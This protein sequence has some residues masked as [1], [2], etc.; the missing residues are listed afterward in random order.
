MGKV[1][2]LGEKAVDSVVNIV[3]SRND[4]NIMDFKQ[5]PLITAIS[6]SVNA[7]ITIKQPNLA[8][9]VDPD[10][11]GPKLGLVQVDLLDSSF[12]LYPTS[13]SNGHDAVTPTSV[14]SNKTQMEYQKGR[15]IFKGL[16]SIPAGMCRY[17]VSMNCNGRVA[18]SPLVEMANE[19][20]NR[21][22][23]NHQFYV[24]L[25]DLWVDLGLVVNAEIDFN[26][27]SQQ[28]SRYN[29]PRRANVAKRIPG[30][31]CAQVSSSEAAEWDPTDIQQ[32]T[33]I[34]GKTKY[35]QRLG[36]ALI[37]IPLLLDST[38]LRSTS[39]LKGSTTSP[40]VST[41][42]TN[43]A[44]HS[45]IIDGRQ[46]SGRGS[47]LSAVSMETGAP[48]DRRDQGVSPRSDR[49]CSVKMYPYSN[50]DCTTTTSSRFG[51]HSGR[52]AQVF[53]RTRRMVNVDGQ[54]VGGSVHTGR[55]DTPR[56]VNYS[57][58]TYAM[59]RSIGSPRSEHRSPRRQASSRTSSPRT[60]APS[61]RSRVVEPSEPQSGGLQS[62]KTCDEASDGDIRSLS[63]QGTPRADKTQSQQRI[64][65]DIPS[66]RGDC[67]PE[68]S[69][70]VGDGDFSVSRRLQYVDDTP[71]GSSLSAPLRIEAPS[72][73]DGNDPLEIPK[74]QLERQASCASGIGGGRSIEAPVPTD[75]RELDMDGRDLGDVLSHIPRAS[76][77]PTLD[78]IRSSYRYYTES[79]MTLQLL[80]F[81]EHKWDDDKYIRPIEGYPTFGMKMPTHIQGYI[82]VRV[83]VYLTSNPKW[84]ALSSNLHH[85][86]TY[87][88]VPTELEMLHVG[89]IL[90]RLELFF[91]AK[92]R[93]V[94]KILLP[95]DIQEHPWYIAAFWVIVFDL[96]VLAPLPRILFDIYLLVAVVSLFYKMQI[97]AMSYANPAHT[98]NEKPTMR[99][100]TGSIASSE[101]PSNACSSLNQT[102]ISAAAVTDHKYNGEHIGQSGHSGQTNGESNQP[103]SDAASQ[104]PTDVQLKT[105]PTTKPMT[106]ETS[107]G[108]DSKEMSIWD[109]KGREESTS[110]LATP[111]GERE[112][113]IQ[114]Y[115]GAHRTAVFTDD[116]GDTNFEEIVK[117]TVVIMQ[118]AQAI[119]GYFIM[120]IE[121]LRISLACADSL[122]WFLTWVVL[123]MYFGP[124]LA[125]TYLAWRIPLVLWRLALY[126]GT[127]CYCITFNSTEKTLFTVLF[128]YVRS[129]MWAQLKRSLWFV[130]NW[131]QRVPDSR[132]ID[133]R[134]VSILQTVNF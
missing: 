64:L 129:L 94:D 58:D 120:G 134:S 63:A 96:M 25:Y 2:E 128:P 119:L 95:R 9:T 114:R 53:R 82:K 29:S 84:L 22:Y 8:S 16:G 40:A 122:S 66:P 57:G 17:S 32:V 99:N 56:S 86:K 5:T 4:K 65:G 125:I 60:P 18:C 19:N 41:S 55:I 27:F 85:P 110:T 92:P 28:Q 12:L 124:L 54:R 107:Q 89:L 50:I 20:F 88:Q 21:V 61:L 118:L 13:T 43:N 109:L 105:K 44:D 35:K 30:V 31:R 123:T 121:K 37:S 103:Q 6:R 52:N 48:L 111:F 1:N 67:A 117:I 80:P 11:P 68:V 116:I 78:T 79:V 7:H 108:S 131:I 112:L 87:W 70:S 83:R 3:L 71:S 51:D 72:L 34:Y 90:R 104:D 126:W 26:Q 14:H 47:L 93:W 15:V 39:Q 36:R 98:T 69:T 24:E 97:G 101:L 45:P 59:Y 38:E 74:L 81:N 132:E 10:G 115:P 113:C 133:H 127:C 91:R 33:S 76:K 49:D 102:Q 106:P 42:P 23:W 77:L 130:T 46:S 100:H 73:L 75:I 62:Y